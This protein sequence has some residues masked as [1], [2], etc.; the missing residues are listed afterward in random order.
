VQSISVERSEAPGTSLGEIAGSA[1]AE[2]AL[3]LLVDA[4]LD[5]F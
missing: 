4:L 2:G 1:V 3:S 5:L